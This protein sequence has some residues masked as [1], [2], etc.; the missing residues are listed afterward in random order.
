MKN[1]TENIPIDP[2]L[3]PTDLGPIFDLLADLWDQV[4]RFKNQTQHDEFVVALLTDL[5]H[6]LVATALVLRVKTRLSG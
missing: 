2:S 5:E 4:V 6:R 1:V 3:D